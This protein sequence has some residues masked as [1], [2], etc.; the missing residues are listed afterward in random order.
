MV[1]PLHG[2]LH[3]TVLRPPV[4]RAVFHFIGQ[5][6]LRVPRYRIYLVLYGGVGLSVV[7]ATVLRFTVVQGD[8]RAEVS[9]DGVR[10]AIGIVAFWVIAGLRTAFVSSGNQRGAW[11]LRIIHGRPANF[12]AAIEQLSA[13]KVWA[14]LSGT[15]ITLVAF[16]ALRMVSPAELLSWPATA[17]QLLLVGATSLLLTDAFFL[18]VT[19]VP[20]SGEPVGDQGNLAFTVLRYF[21]FFPLVTGLSL[22][23]ERW[24]EV[25]GRNFGIVTVSVVVAHLWL[26]K[27][28]RDLI[29]LHSAQLEL[30]EGEDEFPTKLGLL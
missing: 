15:I 29:R 22:F 8:I 5:T 26:R 10:V 9:A 17:A 13:A 3:A 14:A 21:T 30:E 23:V 11:I 7:V 24:T 4:R 19:I 28:H 1:V 6:L 2:L 25:S 20:F 18:N 27:R 16:V 12:A